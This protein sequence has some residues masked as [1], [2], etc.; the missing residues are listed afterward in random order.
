MLEPKKPSAKK[1]AQIAKYKEARLKG[2]NQTKAAMA[3]GVAPSS[4]SVIGSKLE[5][6]PEVRNAL[7]KAMLRAGFNE[8]Y[9][10][11]QIK[12]GADKAEI[13]TAQVAYLTLGRDALGYGRKSS[14]EGQGTTF[15]IMN[16]LASAGGLVGEDGRVE[17]M[18]RPSSVECEV[19][20][21]DD[22]EAGGIPTK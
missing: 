4:A 2:M 6:L 19:V 12:R 3:A 13:G 18:A 10:A 8:E 21:P 17:P 11:R 20:R 1:Q 22:G 9:L 15:N 16:I 14:E 5:K 7:Q